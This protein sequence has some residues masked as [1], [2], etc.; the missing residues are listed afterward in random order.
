MKSRAF[1][2]TMNEARVASDVVTGMYSSFILFFFMLITFLYVVIVIVIRY[3]PSQWYAC[4]C[5]V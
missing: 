3:V 1:Q 4:L 2:L 5:V